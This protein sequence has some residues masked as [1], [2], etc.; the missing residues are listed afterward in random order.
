MQNGANDNALPKP[1]AAP[2]DPAISDVLAAYLAD[3][4]QRLS[5][6]T[7]R[8]YADVI[9][10]LQHS[11]DSYAA[12][13]LNKSDYAI[14]ER[15]FNA[16]GDEHREFCEVFGPEHILPNIAEFL[17]YFMIRKVM[18]GQDLLR[19]SG[20]V[21]KKLSKWLAEKGYV[22]ADEAAVAVERGAG[23]ARDLPK[24]D[25]LA[26]ALYEFTSNKYSP[27]QADIEDHFEIKRVEPGKIWLEGL[28]DMTVLGP[29]SLPV[30]VTKSCKVGWTISGAVGKRGKQYVL[31]EAWNV[32]P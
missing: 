8:M 30:A 19:T 22:N 2:G 16:E 20:T 11:L 25:R 1:G 13:S 3:E 28:G 14:W 12:N 27:E 6:K 7:Y 9:D 17:D 26:K 23:A 21:T 29:I 15:H 31:V 4:K 10:L 18:A 32:Y 24:A 5:A